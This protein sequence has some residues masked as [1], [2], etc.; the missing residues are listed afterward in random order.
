MGVVL[1]SAK[2]PDIIVDTGKRVTIKDEETTYVW[3]V[4]PGSLFV[5][6][7]HT[8]P[9]VYL[10]KE[11]HTDLSQVHL[12]NLMQDVRATFRSIVSNRLN[13][14][15]YE[16][17][18]WDFIP[19]GFIRASAERAG[20]WAL[21]HMVGFLERP[22]SLAD[23]IELEDS[24][25]MFSAL[26]HGP[27]VGA[28]K[29]A[30]SMKHRDHVWNYGARFTVATRGCEADIGHPWWDLWADFEFNGRDY[31]LANPLTPGERKMLY[32][33][34]GGMTVPIVTRVIRLK[35][36][37]HIRFAVPQERRVWSL[38]S[39]ISFKSYRCG[40]DAPI[41]CVQRS[42]VYN[43]NKAFRL[44]A[45]YLKVA[46]PRSAMYMNLIWNNMCDCPPARNDTVYDWMARSIRWHENVAAE[47]E[48][49]RLRMEIE[50]SKRDAVYAAAKVPR[51]K[52][53]PPRGF[54]L[55]TT[56]EEFIEEH[57]AMDHCVNT[58]WS[59]AKL[60][61]YFIFHYEDASGSSTVQLYPDGK[62]YQSHGPHNSM[63]AVQ[64]R[65]AARLEAWA[66]GDW[67]HKE[68]VTE[69][70]YDQIPF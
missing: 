53:E 20:R 52:K 27:S 36:D 43:I 35:A 17:P 26:G 39:A 11:Y 66:K 14:M 59:G 48:A 23:P 64:Q 25:L 34:P 37:G 60:G 19:Q 55:L 31:V 9:A 49:A 57:R 8:S 12:Y 16:M 56:H 70:G 4:V 13:K 58:Y 42:S 63:G 68:D 15:S 50:R 7:I 46:K 69:Q 21:K 45:E 28:M 3:E 62:V 33:M 65:A 5:N 61:K 2:Y 40:I 47:E 41:A 38:L 22:M 30:A 67:Y 10:D 54:K 44:G 6:A 29:Y 51:L 1:R 18:T 32:A 24:G